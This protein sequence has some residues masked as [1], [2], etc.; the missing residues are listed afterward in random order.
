MINKAFLR[1]LRRV[2]PLVGVLIAIVTGLATNLPLAVRADDEVFASL[3][4][5]QMNGVYYPVGKVICEIVN[6][7]LRTHSV[8]CSPSRA[9]CGP[10]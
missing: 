10:I 4:T 1:R 9:W 6:R 2:P 7:D 3:G 8:R 5:G